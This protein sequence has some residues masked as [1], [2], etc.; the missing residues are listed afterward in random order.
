MLGMSISFGTVTIM[1]LPCE[2][3]IVKDSNER[4]EEGSRDT[5]WLERI[6]ARVWK[7]RVLN[8]ANGWKLREQKPV[9]QP[10]SPDSCIVLTIIHKWKSIN[11]LSEEC[12]LQI[13]YPPTYVVYML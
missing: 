5:L 8:E 11:R 10:G 12:N 4:L 7:S 3:E 13:A 1:Y 6:G 9:H 2:V